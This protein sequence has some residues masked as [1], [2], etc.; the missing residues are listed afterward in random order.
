MA[1]CTEPSD[2]TIRCPQTSEF[3]NYGC[4]VVVGRVTGE[5]FQWTGTVR[6]YVKLEAVTF[7]AGLDL[8]NAELKDLGSFRLL[9]TRNN[10]P[11]DPDR[12]TITV[13][14]TA[15]WFDPSLRGI[16]SVR[17]QVR[18]IPVGE[19]VVPDTVELTLT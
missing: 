14:V 6:I 10:A 13:Q 9:A 16:D 4:V 15:R 12:D 8:A 19:I 18:L 2:E 1:G 5:E 11:I 17:R 7:G 3:G